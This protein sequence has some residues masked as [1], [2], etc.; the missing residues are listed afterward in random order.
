MPKS[1]TPVAPSQRVTSFI[2]TT[3]QRME[4]I[5]REEKRLMSLRTL[6]ESVLRAAGRLMWSVQV[7]GV[8]CVCYPGG[9]HRVFLS[10]QPGVEYAASLL[11][12][13]AEIEISAGG[14]D[15]GEQVVIEG[16]EVVALPCLG[17]G[18]GILRVCCNPRIVDAYAGLRSRVSESKKRRMLAGKLAARAFI[19]SREWTGTAPCRRPDMCEYVPKVS[20]PGSRLW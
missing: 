19:S 13:G 8:L 2:F 11:V 1:P 18:G 14:E 4:S 10:Q 16:R 7:Q 5:C 6:R 3:E 17:S 9:S 15:L 12:G 20:S